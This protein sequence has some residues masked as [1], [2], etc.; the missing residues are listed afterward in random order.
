MEMSN[1]SMTCSL[2]INIDMVNDAV[3]CFSNF[4]FF[5]KKIMTF[6]PLVWGMVGC[7]TN[8]PVLGSINLIWIWFFTISGCGWKPIDTENIQ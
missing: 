7:I 5:K 8:F 3:D 6:L 1:V 4:I 2:L